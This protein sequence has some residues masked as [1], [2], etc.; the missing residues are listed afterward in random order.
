M[1]IYCLCDALRW[2]QIFRTFIIPLLCNTVNSTLWTMLHRYLGCNAKPQSPHNPR[3][4]MQKFFSPSTNVSIE[5][6]RAVQSKICKW[7]NYFP[8]GKWTCSLQWNISA[9]ITIVHGQFLQLSN[10]K[11]LSQY[12]H[13]T[14]KERSAE[15]WHSPCEVMIVSAILLGW[16]AM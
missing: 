15:A 2:R 14:I 11:S 4:S 1:T 6:R 5:I 12:R 9:V 16:F 13:Y 10:G 7:V 8:C 3:D